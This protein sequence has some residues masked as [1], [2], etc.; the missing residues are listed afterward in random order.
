MRSRQIWLCSPPNGIWQATDPSFGKPISRVSRIASSWCAIDSC[1]RIRPCAD[2]SLTDHAGLLTIDFAERYEEAVAALAGW[3]S[4]T[5]K[6]PYKAPSDTCIDRDALCRR[7][8]RQAD[9]QVASG[10]N[11]KS[12]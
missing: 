6:M 2:G 9:H 7:E 8:P 1:L 4:N 11:R 12:G 5:E 10:N 3:I